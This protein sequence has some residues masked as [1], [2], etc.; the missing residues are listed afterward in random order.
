MHFSN[1]TL[2]ILLSRIQHVKINIYLNFKL[3][4]C[5]YLSINFWPCCA[6]PSCGELALLFISV[7][8]LLIVVASLVVEHGFQ[9]LSS[10]SMCN[11]W[12]Q[13]WS[14]WALEGMDSRAEAQ[15]L[16]HMSFVAPQHV[17]SS[18]IRDGIHVFCI[19]RQIFNHWTREVLDVVHILIVQPQMSYRLPF[20]I[21]YNN[22]NIY[23]NIL[24]NI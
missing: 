5:I 3:Y 18:W 15:Q 6:F 4:I 7:C 21:I 1:Y 19:G 17:D 23:N 13:H 8:G 9:H 22:Y 14:S 10:F 20:I 12:A 16:R 11:M 2:P 24:Y